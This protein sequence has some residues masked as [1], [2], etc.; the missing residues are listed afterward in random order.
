MSDTTTTQSPT[1]TVDGIHLPAAGPW[2]L[3]PAHT[4]A[5]FSV[6]HLGFTKVRGRF[7]ELSGAVHIGEDPR[8]SHVTVE[9]DAA[10]VDTREPDRDTHLRSEDFLHVEQ[11]PT[12]TFRSRSIARSG[13]R[14]A[15]TGDLSIRGVTRS[16][17]LHTEFGGGAVDPWGD[18]HV[19]FSAQ[20]VIER[21]AF[22]LTWNQALE[23]GGVLVG[24]KVTIELEVSLVRE[25]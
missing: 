17:V 1:R 8:D 9:I 10:S 15:I 20:T 22:G 25:G 11:H 2:V 13:D 12:L 6:R 21:E 18:A 3:D 14:W 16:V 7:T 23:T 19:M 4:S 5:G 24:R